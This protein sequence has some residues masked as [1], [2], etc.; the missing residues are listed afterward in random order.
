MLRERVQPCVAT[1]RH[2]VVQGRDS[3][4]GLV[5]PPG[6]GLGVPGTLTWP[7][8]SSPFC[9]LAYAKPHTESWG[10]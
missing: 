1:E 3:H 4:S 2:E 7:V 8:F 6:V 5:A 10:H 9:Y